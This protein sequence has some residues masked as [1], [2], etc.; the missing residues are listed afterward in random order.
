MNWKVIAYNAIVSTG[1]YV[2]AAADHG[3]VQLRLGVLFYGGAIS[4]QGGRML[5]SADHDPL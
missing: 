5:W 1:D 2:P 4:S 3:L